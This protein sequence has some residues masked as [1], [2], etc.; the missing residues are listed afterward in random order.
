MRFEG[1]GSGIEDL[2]WGQWAA[3]GS[4]QGSG[5]SE[6][7][8]GAIP[9]PEGTTVE[10][11]ANLLGFIMS[12]HQSLRTRLH[13]DADGTPRQ[14]VSGAGEI[15]LEVVD[16]AD[17]EDPAEVA[18]A[19]RARYEDTNFDHVNEWPVRMAVV[20]HHGAI[21][22]F[23]AMYPHIAIDGYGF[24]ALVNDLANLDRATGRHLAPVAG[25]QP[26]EQARQQRTP[27]AR[28]QHDASLRRWEKQLRT[29]AP[30]RYRDS[31]DKRAPRWW[32]ASYNSPAT[33]L[34]LAAVAARTKVHTGP[35]LLAAHAV[36]LA[37]TTG[38]N[39]SVL[40][41][42]VSNRFR[43]GFAE[44]VSALAQSALCV[45]DVADCTFDEAVARAWK[46]LLTAGLHAYYDPR[47]LWDLIDR[48]NEERGVEV[49][50]MCY[51]NDRR[52]SIAQAATGPVP[53]EDQLRAALPLGKLRWGPPTDVPD[54][55][56]YLHIN[57]VPDTIDYTLRVDTHCISPAE[58]EACLRGLESVIVEAA[59]DPALSTGVRSMP[60]PV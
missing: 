7:N 8:G 5:R 50:T 46:S 2:T 22:H 21:S 54:A 60:A 58:M 31:P 27:A 36:L 42:L 32:E 29:I 59:F 41:V 13:Y 39:P 12:R 35:I 4:M 49:D 55:G 47:R 24:E 37:R 52:R 26:L 11:I 40:R 56:C 45:I 18:E 20:R 53:T 19:L 25:T 15:A 30:R 6:A 10:E 38:N 9:L 16:A 43:P 17:D 57:S 23:V 3:W 28:R 14:A 1:D 51:Y 44:S 34:A 33:Y 48:V